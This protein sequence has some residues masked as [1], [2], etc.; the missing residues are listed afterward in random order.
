MYMILVLTTWCWI[1]LRD[2][3]WGRIFCHTQ[4]SIAAFS[5][6]SRV[7]WVPMTFFPFML[8]CLMVS[9][10]FGYSYPPSKKQLSATGRDDWSKLPVTNWTPTWQ[11]QQGIT[12]T[13]NIEDYTRH[14]LALLVHWTNTNTDTQTNPYKAANYSITSEWNLHQPSM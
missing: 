3:P 6:L 11:W 5:S 13:W 7:Q 1:N 10:L 9:Y 12:G 8:A 2:L 14:L 4:H